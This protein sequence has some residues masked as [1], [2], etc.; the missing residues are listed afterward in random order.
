[1][2][3]YTSIEQHELVE[4]LTHYDI[5]PLVNFQG[6][7]AGIENTNYFVD[8]SS[9]RFVLTL[10][11]ELSADELPYFMNVMA[12]LAEH[13]FPSA[14]PVARND[15][16]YLGQFKNKPTAI[17]HCLAGQELETPELVHAQAL[18]DKLGYMHQV[19]LAFSD[20]RIN[21]RGPHW[22]RQ[23]INRIN[24][25]LTPEDAG[26]FKQEIDF[27]LSYSRTRLPRGLIH[28]DLFKD[29]A[30]WQN[31]TLTG[32]I[33]FYYAC[34]DALLYDIAVTANA[35]F[36]NSD[37]SLNP[38]LCSAFLTAYH[39]QRPLTD[40]EHEAWPVM[41]RAAAL[42][43]WLSRLN[44]KIFPKDGEMTHIKNPD[45]FKQILLSHRNTHN[46]LKKIWV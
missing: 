34:D 41:L 22:W 1:M 12:F 26:L 11:E 6:I 23:T 17:V 42:R 4:L 18:G 2:S 35:W 15:G 10:F 37:G 45:E 44:D 43:F 9:G 13:D 21:S 28:A 19:G 33:D 3:V 20:K 32:I 29:N 16:H 40:L 27:Q 46:E 7:S 8:T 24:N 30:L 25:H 36:T 31:T 5:G 38:Q 14:H 39:L